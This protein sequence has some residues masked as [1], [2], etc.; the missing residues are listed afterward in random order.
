M[1]MKKSW[2]IFLIGAL[3]LFAQQKDKEKNLKDNILSDER[4]SNELKKNRLTTTALE[5]SV[6]PT[7]YKV[8]PGDQ[9]LISIW[10]QVNQQFPVMI[11]PEGIL[12]IPT[13]KSIDVRDLSL[14]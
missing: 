1:L 11:S 3:T 13:V 5:S 7:Q 14:K 9:L 4:S 8:G 2:L 6:D 12:L 10:G